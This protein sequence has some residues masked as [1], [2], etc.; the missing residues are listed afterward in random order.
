MTSSLDYEMAK[1]YTIVISGVDGGVPPRSAYV[2][3]GDSL[4]SDRCTSTY[5]INALRDY[6]ISKNVLNLLELPL[7]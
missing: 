1:G 3:H 7:A 4:H 6:T 2:L 5:N